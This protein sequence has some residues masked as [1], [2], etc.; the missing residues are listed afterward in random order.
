V[1]VHLREGAPNCQLDTCFYDACIHA[2]MYVWKSEFPVKYTKRERERVDRTRGL[3]CLA[4]MYASQTSELHVHVRGVCALKICVRL[5][6]FS[7]PCIHV[8]STL[9][10]AMRDRNI[11]EA[12]CA[13][14]DFC[15]LHKLILIKE[16]KI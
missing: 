5:H 10:L 6:G 11:F 14:G 8:H 1:H 7:F 13:S 12:L 2:H 4:E 16:R 9:G 3:P 15:C